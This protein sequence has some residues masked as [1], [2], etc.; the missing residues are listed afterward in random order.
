MWLTAGGILLTLALTANVLAPQSYLPAL[1][2]GLVALV[3][4]A[5]P[6]KQRFLN[7]CH[8]YRPLA[9]FGAAADWDALL[10]GVEQGR[11][12][13]CSCWAA[14]LFPLLLPHGH[15]MAMAFVSILMFCER[16][17]PPRT[18]AWRWRGFAMASRYL[19][20]RLR[21]ITYGL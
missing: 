4:Q 14:M 15:F 10:M 19:S 8:R 6:L 1:W 20:L 18:P 11:W 3:W 9:A 2:L 17:D 12:C 5:S 16:L 21:S 13:I 7:R